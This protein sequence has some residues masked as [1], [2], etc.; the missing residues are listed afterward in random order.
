MKRVATVRNVPSVLFLL[1]FPVLFPAARVDQ[2]N[3]AT[4]FTLRQP[5][6]IPGPVLAAGTVVPAGMIS[7]KSQQIVNRYFQCE[8]GAAYQT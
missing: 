7:L 8:R 3:Q 2:S 4:K 1:A 5:V 6:Q